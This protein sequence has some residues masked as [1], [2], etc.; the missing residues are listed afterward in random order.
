MVFQIELLNSK[1]HDRANFSCGES[2]LDNYIKQRASQDVKKQVSAAFVLLDKPDVEIL[3]YYTLSSYIIEVENLDSAVAKKLP[4]YPAFPATLLGRLAVHQSQ[5]GKQ[6][7]ELLLLDAL[8]RSL[9]ASKEVASLA[10]IVDA[11]ND[12]AVQFYVKYGFRKFKGEPMKLY[13]LMQSIKK[14]F[15]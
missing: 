12:R 5:Q 13:L 1:V 9:S 4:H 7:G 8:N 3:G 14:L 2:S 15:Q 11:L 6:L 10:V